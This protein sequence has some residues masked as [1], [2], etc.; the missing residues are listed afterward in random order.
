MSEFTEIIKKLNLENLM[1]Y[2]I[3]GMDFSRESF[4]RRQTRFGGFL[5]FLVRP[6]PHARPCFGKNRREQQRL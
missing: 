3:Y 6:L 1:S 4:E 5:G 2:L